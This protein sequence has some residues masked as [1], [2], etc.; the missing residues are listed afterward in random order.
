MFAPASDETACSKHLQVTVTAS[1]KTWHIAAYGLSKTWAAP[2]VEEASLLPSPARAW[3]RILRAGQLVRNLW[4]SVKLSEMLFNVLIAAPLCAA[5]KADLCLTSFP[6]L[7]AP[8][9]WLWPGLGVW[10]DLVFVESVTE[11]WCV[12]LCVRVFTSSG[13]T[14]ACVCVSCSGW[15]VRGSAV[16]GSKSEYQS[17][18]HTAASLSLPVP[19]RGSRADEVF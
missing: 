6:F 10:F 2:S 11:K 1:C 12:F 3:S 8:V 16:V 5:V 13:K 19:L 18:S 17:V 7:C 9:I 14:L 4:L 15:A